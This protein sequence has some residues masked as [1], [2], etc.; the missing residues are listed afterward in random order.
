MPLETTAIDAEAEKLMVSAKKHLAKKLFRKPNY[1]AAGEEY[2]NAAKMYTGVRRY[3]KAQEAWRLAA[4]SF[5]QGGHDF[6]AA[7]CM[8]SLGLFTEEFGK[9]A[10]QTAA[11]GLTPVDTKLQASAAYEAA[12]RHYQLDMKVDRQAEMLHK[13]A[14]LQQEVAK[15]ESSGGGRGAPP[16]AL[17]VVGQKAQKEYE[18][19]SAEA[20][21]ALELTW[22][23]DNAKPYKMPELFRA[24]ITEGVRGGNIK[25]AVAAERRLL[26]IQPDGQY[27][28]AKNVFRQL[29]QP[30]HAA[31]AGLEIVVLC[32]STGDYVWARQEMDILG[33]VFG[34]CG[35]R[36][37]VAAAALMAAYGERDAEQLATA[38]KSYHEFN[39]LLPD[40]ARMV[41]KLTVVGVG[42]AAPPAPGTVVGDSDV[43]HPANQKDAVKQPEVDPEEDMR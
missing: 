38:Q 9:D 24:H 42:A 34:F 10:A 40:I 32:L 30:S 4:E 43:G 23:V 31:K 13:A 41:R 26:G 29:N 12:A 15:A 21:A 7:R 22:E 5:A 28:D 20:L 8:A 17:T 3:F 14:K 16:T 1:M 37:E 11:A 19:L 33:G 18:R 25:A 35:S 6:P 2:E 39:F 36:E 27:N